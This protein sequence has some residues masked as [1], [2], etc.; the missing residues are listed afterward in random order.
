MSE[1]NEQ[2]QEDQQKQNAINFENLPA[3]SQNH[4]TPAEFLTGHNNVNDLIKA[5]AQYLAM[6]KKVNSANTISAY[7]SNTYQ[8][9]VWCNK[10][11]YAIKNVTQTKTLRNLVIC[12]EKALSSTDLSQN[13]RALKHA[14]VRKFFEWFGF[15][16]EDYNLD[17]R[18][19]FSADWISKA[20]HNAYKKQPRI[21]TEVFNAIKEQA[22]LGDINDK[23][24]FFLLAFG[25]RRSEIATIKVKD[26]DFL[27]KEINVYQ[28]KTGSNKKLP[29]PVWL[30]SDNVLVKEHV[31]LIFNKSKKCAKTR[32][33]KKVS[34]QFIWIKVKRWIAATNFKKVEIT[35]HSFRRYFVNSLLKQGAS[36]SN[37]AKL[38]G[39]QN[40]NMIQKYGYDISLENNPIVNNNQVKY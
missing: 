37:I 20:D 6:S 36:D 28:V 39:H 24:I 14:S 8:F 30:T 26:I 31:F 5:F 10:L 17:L 7:I 27:N 11:P 2:L 16:H 33:A 32:G 15:M 38:S 9:L 3:I 12:Y 22:D 23:W 34:E 19:S 29:L 40:L 21:N 4:L 1:S 18:K 35:P 13:S 25:C